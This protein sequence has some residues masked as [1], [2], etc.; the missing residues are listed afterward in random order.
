MPVKVIAAAENAGAKLRIVIARLASVAAMHAKT[1][2]R[3]VL[4]IRT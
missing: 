3:F 1:D 4:Q 2:Q